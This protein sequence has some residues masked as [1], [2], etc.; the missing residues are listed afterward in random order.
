[1]RTQDLKWDN[2]QVEEAFVC[3][4]YT[5]LVIRK[6]IY[7]MNSFKYSEN[8]TKVVNSFCEVGDIISSRTGGIVSK[9]KGG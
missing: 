7:E 1:M 4:K 8:S 6:D 5:T 9:I 2:T 3:G